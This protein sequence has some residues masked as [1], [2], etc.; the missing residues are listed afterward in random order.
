[1]KVRLERKDKWEHL[2][3]VKKYE[4]PVGAVRADPEGTVPDIIQYSE[5]HTEEKEPYWDPE[6]S[7]TGESDV[8]A[9]ETEFAAN[10]PQTA[11]TRYPQRYR[12]SA[13]KGG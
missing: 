10:P 13:M 8:S 2:D 1:M 11:D 6:L 7:G 9:D 4:G 5:C 3:N 12:P